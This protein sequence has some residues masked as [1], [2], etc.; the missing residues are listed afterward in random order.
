MAT[1]YLNR[2]GE[3]ISKKKWSELMLDPDYVSVR[4]YD[5]GVIRVSLRWSGCV[6]NFGNTFPNY[7]KVFTL[8]VSNYREDGSLVKDPVEQELT[9]P[10]EASAVNFYEKYLLKWTDSER[11]DANEFVEIGNTLTPPPPPD[12]DRPS[13]E[14][15]MPELGGVGAW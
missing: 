4:E 8:S 3:Q 15:D 1:G 9:F 6:K 2:A 5:N 13:V 11:N 12:P 10:N 14:P 7:Y